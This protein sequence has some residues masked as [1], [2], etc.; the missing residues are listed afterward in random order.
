M[1]TFKNPMNG[2]V[3]TST[4]ALSWLWCFL[5][6]PFYFLVKGNI[7]QMFLFLLFAI[8][9]GGIS[10]FVYPFMIRGI[11]DAK[12]LRTGWIPVNGVTVD[13]SIINVNVVNNTSQSSE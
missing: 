4:G 5:F 6:G 7:K 1:S 13:P 11:N 9:S 8:L 2:M 3:E 10:M 12:Y